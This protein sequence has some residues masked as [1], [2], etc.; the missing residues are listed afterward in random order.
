M[1]EYIKEKKKKKRILV[2]VWSMD[3]SSPKEV[4]K[5]NIISHRVTKTQ[6]GRTEPRLKVRNFLKILISSLP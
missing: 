3:R 5:P 6:V 1:K 2:W 4:E